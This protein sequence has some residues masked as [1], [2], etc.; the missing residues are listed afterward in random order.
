MKQS[1]L[2]LFMLYLK[3]RGDEEIDNALDES[4]TWMCH[5]RSDSSCNFGIT[6]T[7]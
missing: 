6:C 4:Y 7:T 2:M 3:Q 5:T 1:G